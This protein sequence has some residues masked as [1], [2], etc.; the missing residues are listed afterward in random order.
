M[1]MKNKYAININDSINLVIIYCSIVSIIS[2][3]P[4][5]N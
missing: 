2:S 3:F 4:V 5:L 1:K